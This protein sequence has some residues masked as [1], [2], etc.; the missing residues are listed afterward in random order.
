M[1]Y[2]YLDLVKEYFDYLVRGLETMKSMFYAL[3]LITKK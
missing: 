1:L 2:H 3:S